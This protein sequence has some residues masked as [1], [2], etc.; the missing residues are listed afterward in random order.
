MAPKS[1][2]AVVSPKFDMHV[3]ASILTA[4]ELKEAIKEY[5]IFIDLHPR[6]PPLDL[7]MNKILGHWFSF[8]NKI[9]GRAKK[10]LNEVTS[11]LKGW[12]KKFFLID[13]QA[14]PV[15]M[16][17]RHTDIDLR[18]DFLIKYNENDAARLAKIVVPLRPHPRHLLNVLM[19]IWK[20]FG[21]NTH[22]LDSIWEEYGHGS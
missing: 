11:S 16:P 10:C 20:I 6:F 2:Q 9:S 1:S 15:A 12:K 22:D 4:N 13:Q 14:I 3:Y 8:K 21:E 5:C 17:W 7:T 19:S 18:D